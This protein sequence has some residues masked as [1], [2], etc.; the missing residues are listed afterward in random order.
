M[1]KAYGLK[2]LGEK[3]AAKARENGL[4]LAEEAVEVLAKAAYLGMK[5]WLKESA[6]MTSTPIDDV[7]VG[8]ANYAD[9]IVLE[10]IAKLDLDKD[11]Q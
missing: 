4:H 8:F 10:Q 1:E 6:A 11:G 9:P 7:V 2:D 5:D 3:I